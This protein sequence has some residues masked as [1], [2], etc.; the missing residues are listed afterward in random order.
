MKLWLYLSLCLF[1]SYGFILFPLAHFGSLKQSL[2]ISLCGASFRKGK[3]IKQVYK[4]LSLCSRVWRGP[5]VSKSSDDGRGSE[6]H[7]EESRLLPRP[8]HLQRRERYI[9]IKRKRPCRV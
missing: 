3:K 2:P 7:C 1:F 9:V 4:P 8:T 6:V 5:T